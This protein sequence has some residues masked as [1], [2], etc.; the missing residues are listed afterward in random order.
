MIDNKT[1]FIA[2][3][4]KSGTN[5][6]HYFFHYYDSALAKVSFDP[7]D[8]LLNK[9]APYLELSNSGIGKFLIGHS[10]CTGFKNHYKG[11][12]R[13]AWED[14]MINQGFIPLEE[15]IH[16]L[17]EFVDPALNKSVRI[18]FIYRNPLD[19]LVSMYTYTNM[20]YKIEEAY[21][22]EI[23]SYVKVFFTFKKMMKK[24]TDKITFFTYEDLMRNKRQNILDML[25]FFRH[26]VD[27][28]R[29]DAFEK[30]LFLVSKDE[31]QKMENKTGRLLVGE[32]V[33]GTEHRVSHITDGKI[34]KWKDCEYITSEVITFLNRKLDEFDIPQSDFIWE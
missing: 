31:I 23:E 5:M 27:D 4:P 1:A 32:R 28:S 33:F 17:E 9:P 12:K 3:I 26:E 6:L 15:S 8:S 2:T 21:K 13:R 30:A 24:F 20:I 14:L 25:M 34:G 7:S 16:T 29:M 10:Y 18:A 11:D 22:N 19:Q